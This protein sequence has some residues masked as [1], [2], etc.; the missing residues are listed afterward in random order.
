LLRITTTF[1]GLILSG[2]VLGGTW[3]EMTPN[4]QLLVGLSTGPNWATGNKTQT[5]T[6]QPDVEKTY[7]GGSSN[8][9]FPNIE[10]FVGYQKP[11]TAQFMGQ[12]LLS[13]LGL[14]VVGAGSAKLNGDI[15]EDADPNFDNF[16]YD[17]KVNHTRIAVK[18]R[19]ISNSSFVLQPYISG[20][21]GVG[22]NRAT[23]FKITPKISEEVAPPAFAS[24]TTT[25]F[26]YTLGIGV[27]KSL[28]NDLQ[29]AVGYEFADWGNVGLS[30][31]PGQTTNKG[32]TLNHLY[33]N[34]LQL[35]LFYIV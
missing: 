5:I 21:L 4:S 25:T 15:W 6:L 11:L 30:P 31:A 2:V 7:T 24:N 17:Y 16:D 19:L 22:F 9:A 10:L 33:V 26:T 28:T 27:Q 13:Q 35:S 20:S 3:K 32:L 29:L 1:F 23:D 8:K 12:P 14:S 34:S 18:G